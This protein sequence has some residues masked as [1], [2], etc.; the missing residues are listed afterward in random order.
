MLFLVFGGCFGIV[1]DGSP[2][3][4]RFGSCVRSI[5]VRV[6]GSVGMLLGWELMSLFVFCVFVVFCILGMC[7]WAFRGCGSGFV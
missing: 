2:S 4:R 3:P 6:F 5:V 1:C 7:F